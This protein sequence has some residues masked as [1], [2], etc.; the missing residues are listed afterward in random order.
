MPP[1]YSS[2]TSRMNRKVK[3]FS[4]LRNEIVLKNYNRN[5]WIILITNGLKLTYFY[6]KLYDKTH[7]KSQLYWG[8]AKNARQK[9]V[10]K[11]KLGKNDE[12]CDRLV[13]I[14]FQCYNVLDF[15]ISLVMK[16]NQL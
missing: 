3:V 7:K 12:L 14:F 8:G 6:R 13:I 5:L 4:S 16:L 2:L 15:K 9:I 1:D 11:I 10:G